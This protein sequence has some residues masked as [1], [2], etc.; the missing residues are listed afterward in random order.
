MPIN[1]V[2]GQNVYNQQ[3]GNSNIS[4]NS[5][6]GKDAFLKLLVT[7]LRNQDPLN[8]MEDKEFIAQMAQFSTL[9]S[10]Q[11][12]EKSLHT[13]QDDI[14]GAIENLNID[15]IESQI[16]VIKQLVSIKKALEAYGE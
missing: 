14:I 6:L 2:Q 7:Q 15:H 8:P 10:I 11:N 16:E 5:M 1:S 13:S 12:L 9:E 3:A 4:Q